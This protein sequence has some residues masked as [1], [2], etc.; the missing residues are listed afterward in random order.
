M[1]SCATPTCVM[2][3]QV[4]M[5]SHKLWQAVIPPKNAT[6]NSQNSARQNRDPLPLNASTTMT[7]NSARSNT[8]IVASCGFHSPMIKM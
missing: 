8:Q 7:P 6:K 2:N 5:E 1:N 4:V 3:N